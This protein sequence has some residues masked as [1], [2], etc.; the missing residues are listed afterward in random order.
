MKVKPRIKK[1]FKKVLENGGIGIGKA[2]IE[3]GYS[4]NTAKSPTK[5]TETKSWEILLE[6]YLPDDLLTKVTK[7]G[8][9]ATMVKTS[10]TEPD[11][12]LP[13]YA[14]RQRYLETALKMKN[15][16][17]EK[18]DITTNGK[19]ISPVLVKFIDKNIDE[20]TND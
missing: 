19:D 3:E 5:V 7:E 17:I 1:V 8:L 18:K 2:M 14:V 20:P 6:E 15:K 4:P 10:L 16:L 13:D 11:R 9:E 12:T